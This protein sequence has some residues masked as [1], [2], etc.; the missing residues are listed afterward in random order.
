MEIDRIDHRHR[1]CPCGWGREAIPNAAPGWQA[2][3]ASLARFRGGLGGALRGEAELAARE[4]R[5]IGKMIVGWRRSE[6]GG[7]CECPHG[8]EHSGEGEG[9]RHKE[10]GCP[11]CTAVRQ[12]PMNFPLP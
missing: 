9:T 7:S 2:A 5:R 3:V 1:E 10:K 12:C 8:E 11:C 6:H 4:H